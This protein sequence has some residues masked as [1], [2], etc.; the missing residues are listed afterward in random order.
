M[1]AG[2]ESQTA[3]QTPS[4]PARLL[5][6]ALSRLLR[7]PAVRNDFEVERDVPSTARDGVVLLADH[8]VPLTRQARGTVLIRTPYGRGFPG[9]L[10]DARVLAARGYHV[11]FQSCRGTFGSGGQFDPMVN[12]AEDAQDTVAWLRG[13]S[14]FDGRL[15]TLGGSYMGWVQWALL[16][17]P[18]PELRTAVVVIGPHDMSNAVRGTGAFTLND[19]LSWSEMIVH[20]ERTRPLQGVLRT[21][22]TSRRLAT[23]FAGLPL[24]DAADRLL[25]HRAPW[26]RAWLSHP[27]LAEPFW[28]RLKADEALRRV[29]V[30]VRLVGGWQD[31][32]LNQTVHQYEVLRARGVDVS[33]TIGPWTHPQ[34]GTRGAS[35]VVR[36]NLA[37]LDEH[38]AGES[39]ARQAPVQV[40][41]TGA[42]AWRD[43][44][45]WPPSTTEE[46]RFLQ[47]G[48]RLTADEPTGAG[49]SSSFYYD[50]ADP[51]PTLGGG[52]LT[53]DAGVRDNRALEARPDVLTFTSAPLATPLEIVGRPVVEL[54]HSRDNQHADVFVRLCDVDP[55]GRSRNFSDAYARLDPSSP[56]NEVQL[57][58]LRLDPCAHRLPAGH[59]LR[60]QVSGGSHPRFAR[61]EG[62]AG[63]AASAAEL[64]ACIHTVHHAPGAAS[65]VLLPTTL[66]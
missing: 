15:A 61:N 24:A 1:T 29:G 37:W 13:Q 3:A 39:P 54:A 60:L 48:G 62:T 59:R 2:L 22:T 53:S 6:R 25:E 32:F 47:P 11:L 46:V 33:L 19:F 23:A 8:Y 55:R 12:E 35:R 21:A 50:P 14:W 65:R 9:D 27:D 18:P 5:D 31:L 56:A 4:G 7:L 26:F 58:E 57:L 41:V 52:L 43:L 28:D 66:G 20:Q 30:P 51:T 45:T 49:P 63:P 34:V 10:L 17:D 64:R 40:Y 44:P 42:N 16:L 36:G 38:L